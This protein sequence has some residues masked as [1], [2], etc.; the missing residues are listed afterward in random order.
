[1]RKKIVGVKERVRGSVGGLCDGL[2]PRKRVIVVG[3]AFFLFAA[4]S[5]YMTFSSLYKIKIGDRGEEIKIEQIEALPLSGE[6]VVEAEYKQQKVDNR[7]DRER[8]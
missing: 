5:L 3:V 6:G 8:E 4:G 7:D 1:M 2:S